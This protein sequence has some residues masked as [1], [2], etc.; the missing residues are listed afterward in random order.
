M[1][2]YIDETGN[3]G[4]NIFDEDQPLFLT[5]AL[6][7]KVNFDLLE[8]ETFFRISSRF[9]AKA[10]H[11]NELGEA[12]VEAYAPDVLRILEK[13]D[14]RFFIS[15]SEKRYLAV[16]KLVDTLFDCFENKAVPW[17]TY[18][19]RPLRLLMVFKI[20]HILTVEAA[21]KFWGA[22]MEK[23]K[24]R[25]YAQFLVALSDIR[26]NVSILPDV[27]S[28]E[29]ITDAIEWASKNPEGIYLHVNSKSTR[30]GHLP[31]MAVFPNLL[32]GI[33]QRSR[34][35]KRPVIE[36]VHD[37]QSEFQ[38]V[39]AE[40]HEL[41]ANAAPGVI[42]WTLGEKHT[43]RRLNG[44]K[45]RISASSDSPGIQVADTT[46]W[47]F[48]RILADKPIG[49]N[50]AALMEYVFRRGFQNDL[51]FDA[52]G[53]WLQRYFHELDSQPLSEESIAR[54]REFLRIAEQRRQEEMAAYATD[55]LRAL[56][57]LGGSREA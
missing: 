19:F 22:L 49:Q 10:L 23:N 45:F 5:A 31:N 36:V 11:A 46:L 35:W 42:T 24:T 30:A 40:W 7:S 12:A 55:K 34:L 32:E 37:R 41:Y 52:V 17:H 25:A 29:L 2:A 9:G 14:C 18:N 38:K 43:L 20:A 26:E 8:R 13:H 47:L 51:S 57:P 21:K 1:Y 53:A 33:E 44:S 28:R 6:I 27:R 56:A 54:G 16:T 4:K 48:K 39:L 50:S 15:R 3:T